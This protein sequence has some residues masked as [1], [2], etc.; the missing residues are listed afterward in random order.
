MISIGY[1][2]SSR[3]FGFTS[4]YECPDRIEYCIR[5]LKKI[6][7]ENYFIS[8]QESDE[9]EVVS[10]KEISINLM[11]LVHNDSYVQSIQNP[12]VK[13]IMCRYCKKKIPSEFTSFENF[14]TNTPN[15]PNCNQNIKKNSVLAYLSIDT[16]CTPYTFSVVSD[17]VFV[18]SKLVEKLGRSEIKYGFGL[19]RPPGHHCN[20]DA[21]G[22][23]IVNNALIASRYAQTQGF[24]K[25]LILDIDFHHGDGTERLIK[26]HPDPAFKNIY[27]VSIHGYGE[28]IYPNSGS[29]DDSNDNILNLPIN[30]TIDPESRRYVTDEFYQKLFDSRALPWIENINPDLIVISNGYDS[31]REDTLEGFNITDNTYSYIAT[32]LKYLDKPLL[33]VT[34]GGYSIETISRVTQKMINIYTE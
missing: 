29:S 27:M 1:N 14:I 23:C 5:N 6:Y 3:H 19:V 10:R 24:N 18:L 13:N 16:Y 28:L 8:A 32:Q 17:A 31:H 26:N 20:N 9:I 21:N 15:C 33:F 34:E 30:I 22:F 2:N 12:N 4:H 11:K 7:P 25:I